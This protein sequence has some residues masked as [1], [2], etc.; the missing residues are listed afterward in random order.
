MGWR[1]ELEAAVVTLKVEGRPMS[2]NPGKTP[3]HANR[4]LDKGQARRAPLV[5]LPAL[6]GW[7]VLF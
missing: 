3:D 4:K 2:V 1:L 7:L 5:L 6:G